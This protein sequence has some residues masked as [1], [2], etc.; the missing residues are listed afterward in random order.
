MTD[1][2]AGLTD[3]LVFDSGRQV[4]S[5]LDG[6]LKVWKGQPCGLQCLATLNDISRIIF[7]LYPGDQ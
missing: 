5:S 4:I 1:H 7:E 2:S 6:T 3:L